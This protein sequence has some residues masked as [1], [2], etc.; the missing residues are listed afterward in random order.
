LD[1]GF[2]IWEDEEKRKGYTDFEELV[3]PGSIA[4]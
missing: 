4:D 2:G 1:F 3:P